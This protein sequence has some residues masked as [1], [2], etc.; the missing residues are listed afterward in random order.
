MSQSHPTPT[1][2]LTQTC[3]DE[4]ESE[5]ESE[6]PPAK[7]QKLETGTETEPDQFIVYFSGE[8]VD[9]SYHVVAE[10]K[11]LDTYIPP[12]SD[13]AWITFTGR[14]PNDSDHLPIGKTLREWVTIIN[15]DNN[16]QLAEW[17]CEHL[18]YDARSHFHD[19]K[20]RECNI[21][22]FYIVNAFA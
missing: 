11:L 17:L 20:I 14:A 18:R 21:R 1:I 13:Q 16:T 19:A 10:Y 8:E 12:M 7:K 3:D 6:S 5:S 22:E 4:S 9:S 2:D 15:D